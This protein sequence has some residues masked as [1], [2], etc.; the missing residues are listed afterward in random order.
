MD[1]VVQEQTLEQAEAS[2][3]AHD[4]YSRILAGQL[5]EVAVLAADGRLRP[6]EGRAPLTPAETERL[7]ALM[8]EARA[9]LGFPR[10]GSN[11][12]GPRVHPDSNHAYEAAAVLR[13]CLADHRVP[14]GATS[15]GT[16][17]HDGL[18]VRYA[19]GPAPSARIDSRAV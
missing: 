12:I 3:R 14:A 7:R 19:A 15:P 18:V 5:G 4:L 8:E 17:A 13:K 11:G 6:A 9:L 10:G 16:H 1:V 2:L